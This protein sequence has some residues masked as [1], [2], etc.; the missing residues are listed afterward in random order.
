MRNHKKFPTLCSSDMREFIRLCRFTAWSVNVVCFFFAHHEAENCCGQNIKFYEHK[1]VYPVT[2]CITR[3]CFWNSRNFKLSPRLS[4]KT[5]R[6]SA[7]KTLRFGLRTAWLDYGREVEWWI[8]WDHE[9]IA[10]SIFGRRRLQLIRCWEFVCYRKEKK[11][12]NR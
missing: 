3:I 1:R 7:S 6:N 5:L 4:C 9:P 8:W 2:K 11:K 12:K 10:R